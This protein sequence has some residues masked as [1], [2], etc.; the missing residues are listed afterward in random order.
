MAIDLTKKP[1]PE[2]IEELT[3]LAELYADRHDFVRYT[4]EDG[5]IVHS[6]PVYI[7]KVDLKKWASDNGITVW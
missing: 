5:C 1:L 6:D 2:E 4:I 7:H 3:E